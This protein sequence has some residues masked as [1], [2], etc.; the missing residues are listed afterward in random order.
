MKSLKDSPI[1]H[2]S[3]PIYLGVSY[4]G[5]PVLDAVLG[6][7]PFELSIVK[8]SPVIDDDAIREF[9]VADDRLPEELSNIGF[10]NSSQ[11]LRFDLVGEVID[12]H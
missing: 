5:E 9:E 6:A 3:F 12:R 10:C 7:E 4:R 2:L 11:R 1:S 8:P